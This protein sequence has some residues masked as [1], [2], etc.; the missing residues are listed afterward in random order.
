MA[1]F[2]QENY[3]GNVEYKLLFNVRTKF[4]LDK[5]IT[6]LNYR[7]NEGNGYA[8]YII[9]ITDE[10]YVVGLDDSTLKYNLELIHFMSNKINSKVSIVLNCKYENKDFF[11]V[12][13]VS[14]NYQPIL[15]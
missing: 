1:L 6:Q 15:F 14:E 12:K 3:Y 7:I 13:I 4:R 2:S 5:Y 10:G 11:I 8:I 9:G